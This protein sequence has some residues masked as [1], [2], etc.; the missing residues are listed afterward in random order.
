M[1]AS[2][3]RDR[4]LHGAEEAERGLWSG[5]A[6]GG[7]QGLRLRTLVRLR[8]LAVLGQTGAVLSVYL[9]LGFALPL[10]WCLAAIA[11]SAWLNVFLTLRRRAGQMLADRDAA[12]L[13]GYDIL[14]LAMLLYLTGGIENPFAFLFL[15]PVTVSATSLPLKWTLWLSGLAFVCASLLGVAHR[16]LPWF[17]DAQLTLPDIYV[18][19]MWTAIVS[20]VVFSA[21]YARRIAEEARQ[22]STALAATEVVLAREQRLSALDGLAAAAA[23]ELGTPLATIA[24]VAKELK[25]DLTADGPIA[26]DIDLLISQAG[27]CREILARLA[28]R[29]QPADAI[30]ARVT[31]SAMI[32]DIVAPLRG[33]DITIKVLARAADD[34]MPRRAGEP[35]FERN[36]AVTYGLGNL[37]ENAADFASS[38]VE[39]DARWSASE[40]T[41]EIRDDGPGV[42]QDILDRLGD[43]YVTTRRGYDLDAAGG[44]G[45]EGMGLGFFIAKTLLERTGATVKLANRAIPDRG[46]LVSIAWPRARIDVSLAGPGSAG[47][48][49]QARQSPV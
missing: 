35:I 44:E 41:M 18:A 8:W 27:R 4:F 15:V 11:L 14:Q 2:V 32:E 20:G 31:L 22:M 36:P 24:L 7:L 45:H 13:L 42:A 25:R 6:G 19:G 9:I 46:A 43:P 30:L 33:A 21:I 49:V 16:P 38:R 26:E 28:H 40:V 29:D 23:H 17:K 1:D 47:R 3:A 12:L 10:G 34:G 5:L 48:G 39:I 37:I